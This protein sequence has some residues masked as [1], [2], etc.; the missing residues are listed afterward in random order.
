MDRNPKLH[1]GWI[2]V[3]TSLTAVFGSLG[4]ARFGYTLILPSMKTGLGLTEIQVS[5]LA[6]VNMIGYLFL[7]VTCGFLASRFGPRRIVTLSMVM[8][9]ASLL[10]T[11]AAAGF[12][13]A[14]LFRFLSGA[15]SG[16]V[17]VPVMGLQSSWFT[18]QKRGLASGIVVSGSSFGLLVTG[19][20]IPVI[21]REMSWR[22]A[23]YSLAL[24]T[25]LAAFFCC[26]ML[27]NNPSEKGL[28]PVGQAVEKNDRGALDKS[29]SLPWSRLFRRPQ[30]LYLALIYL[31]FGFSY[32]IYTTFFA[33]Y[34]ISEEGLTSA[35]AGR[36]WSM[37]GIFSIGS[38]FLWGSVSDHIGRKRTLAAVFFLQGLSFLLF[39]LW[40]GVPGYYASAALFALTA[41]SIPAVVA[42]ATGD[43]LGPRLASA[44]LGFVTLF[45]GIG[46]VAGPFTAGRIAALAG[47]YAPAFVTAGIAASLG[48]VLSV[49]LLPSAATPR[50]ARR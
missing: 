50:S 38:G 22:H 25:L 16:G 6:T 26:L 44:G 46:Q 45:F 9:S 42:A 39:G 11:G 30:L 31:L 33:H 28:G 48:A 1:Y 18:K 12:S 40:Q 5:D 19:L 17:N 13:A 49:L 14:L 24:I 41:W 27:R 37:V 35:S 21:L 10:M 2:I 36:I 32:V 7:S 15:G 43:I 4:L 29:Q 34:L 20:L 3:I 47:S 23:W 8:V